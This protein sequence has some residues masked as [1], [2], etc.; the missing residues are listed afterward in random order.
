[1]TPDQPHLIGH[2]GPRARLRPHYYVAPPR[3]SKAAKHGGRGG[4]LCERCGKP[5]DAGIHLTPPPPHP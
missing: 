1:M 3:Y 4:A 2:F 5:W